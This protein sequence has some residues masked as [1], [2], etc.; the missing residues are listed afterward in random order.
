MQQDKKRVVPAAKLFTTPCE[1]VSCV[2]MSE[3]EFGDPQHADC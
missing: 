2:A 1:K 3:D